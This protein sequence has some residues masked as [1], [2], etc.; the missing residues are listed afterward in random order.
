MCCPPFRSFP[1]TTSLHRHFHQSHL[2]PPSP[3]KLMVSFNFLGRNTFE[4][5]PKTVMPVAWVIF[6]ESFV[7]HAM[8]F[9]L[10][11]KNQKLWRICL[12]KRLQTNYI[13][14]PHNSTNGVVKGR[15][16]GSN[17]GKKNKSGFTHY[18]SLWLC[19]HQLVVRNCL[20]K[21]VQPRV[22]VWFL[23]GWHSWAWDLNPKRN[24]ILTTWRFPKIS[25]RMM[26]SQKR[27]LFFVEMCAPFLWDPASFKRDVCL[28]MI[29][30]FVY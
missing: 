10:F 19:K 17:Q 27:R 22:P 24:E 9:G 8:N 2:W 7:S 3:R 6:V 11:L 18:L 25:S 28:T 30:T 5:P 29:G 4:W 13:T 16:P 20:V 15:I 1:T 23:W 14:S 12:A 26:L 21:G